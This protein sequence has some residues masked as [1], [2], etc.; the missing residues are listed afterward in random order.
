MSGNLPEQTL[1]Y[2]RVLARKAIGKIF[3]KSLVLSKVIA[4]IHCS[5]PEC[6]A[7]HNESQDFFHSFIHQR[8]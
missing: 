2:G 4:P 6:E 3:G 8:A 1:F 5:A 7:P